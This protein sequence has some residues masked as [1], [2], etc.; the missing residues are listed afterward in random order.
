MVWS[1]EA[2]R[3]SAV[4]KALVGYTYSHM[5]GKGKSRGRSKNR[6]KLWYIRGR[7]R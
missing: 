7:V 6:D 1:R 4:V 3:C 5:Q 2:A